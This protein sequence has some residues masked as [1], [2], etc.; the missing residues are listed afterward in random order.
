VVCSEALP[1]VPRDD[2]V[3]RSVEASVVFE[4]RRWHWW[5]GEVRKLLL[6][7]HC[8]IV[9]PRLQASARYRW[10]LHRHVSGVVEVCVAVT[11]MKL[12]TRL[13]VVGR[14]HNPATGGNHRIDAIA[15]EVKVEGW[16]TRLQR[17]VGPP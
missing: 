5:S 2:L 4:L 12:A 9:L 11:S 6:L 13:E 1:S 15:I 10:H 8:P 3:L 7:T 16:F 14:G 17:S